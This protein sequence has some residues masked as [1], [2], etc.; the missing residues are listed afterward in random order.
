MAISELAPRSEINEEEWEA[1]ID[2]A[3]LYRI[4]ARLGKADR[5][6]RAPLKIL[7]SRASSI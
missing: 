5:I 1:R 6:Y 2:L 3:A 7:L 4:F